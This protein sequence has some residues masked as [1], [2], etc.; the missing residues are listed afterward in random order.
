MK[1]NHFSGNLR[2]HDPS[3]M[4]SLLSLLS[5]SLLDGLLLCF[6]ILITA[7]QKKSNKKNLYK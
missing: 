3:N 1:A 5:D 7:R 6:C 4:A 2:S